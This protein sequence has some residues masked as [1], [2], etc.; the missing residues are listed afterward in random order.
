[1]DP[2]LLKT[3]LEAAILAAKE[4]AAEIK[5]Q[6]LKKKIFDFIEKLQQYVRDLEFAVNNRDEIIKDLRHEISRLNEMIPNLKR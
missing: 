2:I 4:A 3:L 1:M 6:V 5:D